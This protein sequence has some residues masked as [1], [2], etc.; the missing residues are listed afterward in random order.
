MP[1]SRKTR[2]SRKTKK[3]YRD[4][5]FYTSPY[6]YH[7]QTRKVKRYPE[8]SPIKNYKLKVSNL[9]TVAFST[10]GNKKGKPVIFVHGGPGGATSSASARFFNPKKYYIVLVDQR[11]CGKSRPLN[12]TREN[13]T[14]DLIQ[15]FEKIR[16]KLG[17]KK[18]MVFGGSWGSTLSLAYAI[19]HPEV[20]TELVLRGIFL[21][22]QQEIDWVTENKYLN[23]VN[24][25]GWDYY[26]DAIPE[27]YR[28]NF[29][30]AFEKCFNGDF[31][32]DKRE[33][34]YMAWA[35]W[36]DMSSSL[37]M[38][39]LNEF[40]KTMKKDKSYKTVAILEH[41]YF[42]NLCFM[43]EGHL[44]KKEN[45]DRIRHIPTYIVQGIYDL[46]CPFKNAFTLHKHLPEAK[47]Y[48]TLSGHSAVDPENASHLVEITN[49][50]SNK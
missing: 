26:Q 44:T 12:E 6:N 34:C 39:N 11:G 29:L 16:N 36:E 35:A 42:K 9:H 50:L 43:K 33:K 20:V 18:W 10:Y 48:P 24:A 30:T 4:N 28:T 41:H 17:I 46:V 2:Q 32:S 7:V 38:K 40:I 37:N 31:G 27:K 8:T 1:K 47:F 23:N 49:L 15:D 5:Y 3:N 13:T 45:L 14:Q 22:T 19:E 25:V 21:G